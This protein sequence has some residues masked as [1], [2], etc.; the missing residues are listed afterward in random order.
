MKKKLSLLF[1]FS[2]IFGGI[3][4]LYIISVKGKLSQ[5]LAVFIVLIAFTLT[6]INLLITIIRISRN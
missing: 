3:F 2:P 4:L 6:F 1:I 5:R